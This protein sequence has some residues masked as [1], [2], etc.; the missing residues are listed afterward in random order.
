MVIFLIY[1]Q[2]ILKLEKIKRI[3]SFPNIFYNDSVGSIPKWN[4]TKSL[5]LKNAITTKYLP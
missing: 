2:P 5:K 4:C 3:A 1:I